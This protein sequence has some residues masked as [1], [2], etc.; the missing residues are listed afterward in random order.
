MST[1]EATTASAP[2]Q[3]VDIPTRTRD[4]TS[5][6]TVSVPNQFSALGAT[7]AFPAGTSGSNGGASSGAKIATKNIAAS[8]PKASQ[9]G[10][11]VPRK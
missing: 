4:N 2:H 3:L 9:L 10:T 6:P 8:A 1:P 7:M 11:D 5:R